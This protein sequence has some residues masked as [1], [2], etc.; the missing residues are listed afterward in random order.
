MGSMPARRFPR[1]GAGDGGLRSPAA[2]PSF[3]QSAGRALI[4]RP[5]RSNRQP[6]I[7]L[8]P[9]REASLAQ[10]TPGAKERRRGVREPGR[11]REW[12]GSGEI[13]VE[14]RSN[15]YNWDCT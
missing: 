1:K 10:L 9:E 13:T 14:G 11:M 3:L 7:V 4:P 12:L 5:V 15:F 2:S 6:L 8:Q